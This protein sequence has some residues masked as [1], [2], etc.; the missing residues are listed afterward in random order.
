MRRFD[1]VNMFKIAKCNKHTL[2]INNNYILCGFGENKY[3]QLGLGKGVKIINKPIIL[4]KYNKFKDVYTYLT[5][6][7]AIDI[8]D[9]I[10]V[11]GVHKSFNNI[12]NNFYV[13]P[14]WYKTKYKYYNIKIN[15]YGHITKTFWRD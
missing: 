4:I 12:L 3:F 11:C 2:Y 15:E 14:Q 8:D 9:Y 13:I 5:H 1:R 6:S 10:W 7:I